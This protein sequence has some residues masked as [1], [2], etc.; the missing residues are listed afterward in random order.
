MQLI[1]YLKNNMKV[2]TEQKRKE[3]NTI[4]VILTIVAVIA[5]IATLLR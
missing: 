2:L 5:I 3:Q 1:Y 4:T